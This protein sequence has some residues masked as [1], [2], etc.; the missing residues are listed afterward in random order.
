MI[1]VYEVS[2][3]SRLAAGV[4]PVTSIYRAREPSTVHTPGVELW[5]V[6][7]TAGLVASKSMYEIVQQQQ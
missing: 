2:T 5:Q 6:A 7:T 3:L 4:P 1:V